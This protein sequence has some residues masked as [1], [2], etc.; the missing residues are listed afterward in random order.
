MSGYYLLN[1]A[2]VRKR[3]AITAIV[4]V[5]VGLSIPDTIDFM[6]EEAPAAPST[7]ISIPAPLFAIGDSV[8]ANNGGRKD[9]VINKKSDV[10]TFICDDGMTLSDTVVRVVKK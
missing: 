6:V 1:S 3:T 4:G 9:I 2:I 8:C 7:H 5:V 10:F